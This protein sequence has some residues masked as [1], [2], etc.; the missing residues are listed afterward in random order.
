MPT[1]IKRKF[2]KTQYVYK[3]ISMKVVATC[4]SPD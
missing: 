3:T 2:L 1:L 4:S